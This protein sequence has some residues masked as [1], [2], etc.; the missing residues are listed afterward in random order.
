MHEEKNQ[1]FVE[2]SK[3]APSRVKKVAMKREPSR[4]PTKAVTVLTNSVAT[5][6]FGSRK[7]SSSIIDKAATKDSTYEPE[8]VEIFENDSD[9]V[10]E[11][12]VPL[13]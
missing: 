12:V 1:P 8:Q 2:T 7:R 5:E 6:V 13:L 11:E 9:R 10:V 4:L 3:A